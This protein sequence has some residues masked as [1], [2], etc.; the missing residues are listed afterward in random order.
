MAE[1]ELKDT[2]KNETLKKWAEDA[3]E[4]DDMFVVE[5][6]AKGF[7]GSQTITV[8]VDGD[9]GL[10]LDECTKISRSLSNR[11]EEE[12][13]IAGK[14][15]L[16]VSSPGKERALLIPRQ[17]SKHVGRE[18]ELHVLIDGEEK[19]RK[20]K[21]LVSNPESIDLEN[22]KGNETIAHNNITKARIVL[23]W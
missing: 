12:D 10:S 17:Y 11:L 4:R 20:G 9:S 15:D 6:E 19:K 23:P 3:F 13:L 8:Y 18:I 21:L 2:H 22:S 7:T 16:R 14:F 1:P 5:V